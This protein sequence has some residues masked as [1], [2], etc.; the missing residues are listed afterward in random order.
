MRDQGLHNESVSEL[1][2]NSGG[3]DDWV[4]TTAFYA[5][6]KL[7]NHE[8]F[9]YTNGTNIYPDF[10]YYYQ[11]L[12]FRRRKCKHQETIQLVKRNIRS[13]QAFYRRLHDASMTARYADYNITTRA[14]A[15]MARQD[16][17]AVKLA[18]AKP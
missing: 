9:P 15:Q 14:I 10:N 6:L 7:V 13:V 2:W 1:L 8:L 18:C 4:V 5:A 3:F 16:L 17:A 11:T 12:P